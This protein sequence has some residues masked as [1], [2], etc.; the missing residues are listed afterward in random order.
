M[1]AQLRAPPENRLLASLPAAEFRRL[2]ARRNPVQLDAGATLI[3]PGERIR[4]VLF[5]IDSLVSLITP[6]TG[7][8]QLEVG[9]IGDEGMLGAWLILGVNASP[10][11]AMVLRSGHA[12]RIDAEAFQGELGRSPTLRRGLN[13]FLYVLLS[14]LAQNVACTRFHVVEAR[15]AR[16]LLMTRDRAHSSQI[17]ITHES[18]ASVLGVRRVGVTRA[19]TSLARQKLIRYSRGELEILDACGLEGAACSCYAAVRNTYARVLG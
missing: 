19:A 1:P 8:G 10:L 9:L 7:R 13:R 16:L 14:Q 11:R 17:H 6:V 2:L 4:Q 5:P 18:L 12:W 3:E 15:L